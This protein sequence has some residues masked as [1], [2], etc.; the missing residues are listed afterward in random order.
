MIE[1]LSENPVLLL[2]IVAGVGYGIGGI[3]IRG[4]SLGVAAILFTGLFFGALDPSLRIP[5]I[6]TYLGLSIFV[7]TVGLSS[8]PGFFSTFK[9][10][11]WQD[12]IFVAAMLT[13]SAGIA[14]AIH[15]LFELEPSLTAGIFAGSTTNTPALAGL[16]DAFQNSGYAEETRKLMSEQT[17]IGYSIS[18]PMGVLGPILVIGLARR[19]F[20]VNYQEEER[21]LRHEYPVR[22]DILT[23]TVEIKNPEIVGITIRDLKDQHRWSVLFGRHERKDKTELSHWDTTFELGD[24]VAV[25]GDREEVE[26]VAAILGEIKPYQLSYDQTEYETRRLFVSNSKIGG[27]KLA[28]LNLPEK[29]SAMISRVRRGDIDLLANSNTVLEL[30]DRVRVV[31]RRKD[32]PKLVQL[33]GDSYDELSKIDLLSFGLG[34]GLGMVLGMITFELP[35]G[36][37]FRLGYAGGPIIVGLLLGGLRRSGPIHWTLPYSANLLLRQFGL[38][39]MLTGIGVNSGYQFRNMMAQGGEGLWIFLGGMIVSLLTV[40]LTILVGF[41]LLKIPYSILIGMVSNHPA[42]L[43]FS[44]N[45]SKN[46]LPNIGYTIMTPLAIVLKIVYAQLLFLLLS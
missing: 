39:F 35:G 8:G 40:A 26:A 46:K 22:Q 7:Y 9:Q 44:L 30:G 32:M 37:T 24:E 33:F 4:N 34:M 10:R 29:F 36:L 28:S 2:F 6:V 27:E 16:F 1:S 19:L 25:V 41:K 13:I 3:K 15:F 20:R 5:E 45:Q 17:V 11:G 43:D 31:A 14:A 23:V 21:K 18:Y 12:L 38:I 42:I